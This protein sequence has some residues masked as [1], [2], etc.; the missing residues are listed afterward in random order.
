MRKSAVALS[1]VFVFLL[2]ALAV[3]LYH[4]PAAMV[5]VEIIQ[6]TG[7]KKINR[8]PSESIQY[9]DPVKQEG[10]Y[11]LY[12]NGLVVANHFY[13]GLHANWLYEYLEEKNV[14]HAG[15]YRIPDRDDSPYTLHVVTS[16]SLS[17]TEEIRLRQ[18]LKWYVTE[19]AMQHLPKEVRGIG[20]FS[21][22]RVHSSFAHFPVF[23]DDEEARTG[24]LE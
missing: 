14:I 1:A 10:L 16:E 6:E 4:E 24:I 5:P 11:L 18:S 23:R 9:P 2:G 3:V 19:W 22:V 8:E 17:V 7:N 20:L 12:E 13:Y 15:V 21:E